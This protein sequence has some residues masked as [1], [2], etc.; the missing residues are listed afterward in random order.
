M[1]G[2][3]IWLI[4]IVLPLP[5]LLRLWK[6][7]KIGF[8]ET[9]ITMAAAAIAFCVVYALG[10]YSQTADVEIISGAVTGKERVH[11]TYLETYECNCRTVKIGNTQTRQC[12]TCTRR[13]YTVTWSVKSNIGSFQVDHKDWTSIAVYALPDP[14]RY[15]IVEKGDPVAKDATYTNYVRGAAESLFHDKIVD[16]RFKELIPQYPS[17]IY[18]LYKIDRVVAAGL[19][20][21]DLSSWNAELSDI[22]CT[23]GPQKQANVVIVLVNTNDTKYV[24]SLERAWLGG[25]K[26]DIVVV[27]GVSEYPKLEWARVFS[28]TNSEEFKINLRDRLSAMKVVDRTEILRTIEKTTHESFV[29]RDLKEFEYLADEI[30]PPLWAVIVALI[31]QALVSI[32]VTY[33]FAE[34]R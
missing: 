34:R 14:N 18:D 25:K 31:L 22:Q 4:L 28:W 29:R 5:W 13:H 26:N 2:G 10:T 20:V 19:T 15:T 11:D 24:N 6:P 17:R 33:Y 1:N 21:P 7:H 30:E 27:L 3:W 8:G 16:S 23:L 9:A 12:S 32:G